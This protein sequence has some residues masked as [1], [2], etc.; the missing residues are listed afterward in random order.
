MHGDKHYIYK[1]NRT[2]TLWKQGTSWDESYCP[3]L[4]FLIN[5][6]S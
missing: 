3:L 4:I 1:I 6:E 2:I 5:K